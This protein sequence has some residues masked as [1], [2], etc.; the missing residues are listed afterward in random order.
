MKKKYLIVLSDYYKNIADG[1]LK[2]AKKNCKK[3]PSVKIIKE[4]IK[5]FILFFLISLIILLL[6]GIKLIFN[7]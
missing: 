4:N 3:Y 2:S 1:L 7:F 5:T 6:L